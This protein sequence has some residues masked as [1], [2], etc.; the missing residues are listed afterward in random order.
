VA[1]RHK[2]IVRCVDEDEDGRVFE[3]DAVASGDP[4]HVAGALMPRAIE[5]YVEAYG[6]HPAIVALAVLPYNSSIDGNDEYRISDQEEF[7]R[8]EGE[9]DVG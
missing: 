4:D 5:F 6:E 8:D 7:L 9:A 1:R 3:M 2:Y